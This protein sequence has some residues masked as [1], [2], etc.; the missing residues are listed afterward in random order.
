MI[1]GDFNIIEKKYSEEEYTSLL[2]EKESAISENIRL[3]QELAWLRKETFGSKSQKSTPEKHEDQ[4]DLFDDNSDVVETENTTTETI[5]YSRKKRS[6]DK[7]R[8]PFPEHLE[9]KEEYRDIP[10]SQKQCPC[11][12]TLKKIGEEVT[13]T[14]EYVPASCYVKCVIR[15]KYACSKEAERGIKIMHLPKRPVPEKE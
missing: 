12:C 1:D 10:E 7:E 5:T 11:G 13:E 4:V 3:K 9:R 8:Q 15:P 2:A 14:L 6:S